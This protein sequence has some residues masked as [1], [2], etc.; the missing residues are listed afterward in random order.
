MADEKTVIQSV[1][2]R[3]LAGSALV[4]TLTLEAILLFSAGATEAFT[5]R[6]LPSHVLAVIVG[7][8]GG[9]IFELFR[10]LLSATSNSLMEL[11]RLNGSLSA[12]TERIDYQET[13]LGM[14]TSCPR[15]NDALSKLIR[16]SMSDNFRNIP[17]VGPAAYLGYL[18]SAVEHSDGYE[19][20]QRNTLRWY[21][22]SGATA[23]LIELKSKRM[24]FKTRLFVIDDNEAE[25][26]E[27][28]LADQDL[29][30]FYWEH[31][32]D[33]AS[34]WITVSDFRRNYPALTVPEDFALYDHTLLISY[35]EGKQI[36][37]FDV[38]D[39]GQSPHAQIFRTLHEL[40]R[41]RAAAFRT[42]PH[43]ASS[44]PELPH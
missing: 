42:V 31:T 2:L 9:W 24:K 4:G 5:A 32:G 37:S 44:T 41:H 8:L 16:S 1:D 22:E 15:H 27:R 33:V 23:Y 3:R 28:D 35:D 39:P 25:Q 30:R 17:Y 26:M 14:L 40:T 19:G 11:S 29:L 43:A 20:I 10:A 34:Y 6:Q 13:A 12:L 36:L 7:T 21:Q 18:R 38:L